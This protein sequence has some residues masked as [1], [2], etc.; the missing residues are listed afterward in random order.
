VTEDQGTILMGRLAEGDEHAMVELVGRWQQPVCAF[1]CRFLGCQIEEAQDLA[2][3][4]F[5]KVWHQRNRWHAQAKFS[6][7]LFTIVA[8]L[9]RNQLRDAGRRPHLV[10][11]QLENREDSVLSVEAGPDGDPLALAEAAELSRRLRSA[12]AEL[13]ERQR[14]A[15]LLRRFAGLRYREIADILGVSPQS[16]DSL[17][18]RARRFLV[19]KTQDP[20]SGGVERKER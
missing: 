7:W 3:E 19:E 20:A 2:Q 5:L 10:P 1:I 17:L 9:C 15:F 13:P 4:V 18:V 12:V 8:N 11:V 14:E 16:V 6:T